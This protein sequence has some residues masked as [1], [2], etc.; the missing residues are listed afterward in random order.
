MFDLYTPENL[1]TLPCKGWFTRQYLHTSPTTGRQ[2]S[3][4]KWYNANTQ[5]TSWTVIAGSVDILKSDFPEIFSLLAPLPENVKIEKDPDFI[6]APPEELEKYIKEIGSKD[7][8]V[9]AEAKPSVIDQVKRAG[10]P[11]WLG[12]G[13]GVLLLGAVLVS[14]KK[15]RKKGRKKSRKR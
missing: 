6:E 9:P 10:F 12:I 11:V 1:G 3:V 15:K 13:M 7:P 8:E 14:G 5:E 4:A 2:V